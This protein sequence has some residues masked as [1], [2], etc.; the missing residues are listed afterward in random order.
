MIRRNQGH[1]CACE[2]IETRWMNRGSSLGG[3]VI[4]SIMV[5]MCYYKAGK[6]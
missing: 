5:Y 6:E 2:L 3:H 1:G 4:V